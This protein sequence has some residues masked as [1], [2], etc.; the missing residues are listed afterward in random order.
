M[1][2]KSASARSG[3]VAVAP[4]YLIRQYFGANL[5]DRLSTRPFLTDIEK[6]W[7]IYQL[8]RAVEVSH[9]EGIMHGDIKPENFM[10]TSWNFIVL[11]DFANFKPVYMPDDD[12]KDFL[13]F[14]DSMGRR[15]CYVA[16]ERF[17]KQ[18]NSL[19]TGTTNPIDVDTSA[20]VNN[21]NSV[22]TPAMDV[23]SL[24]CTI[25]EIL[26]DGE[27]LIDLPGMLKYVSSNSSAKKITNL[28][29]EESP[30]LGTINRILDVTL[31]EVLHSVYYH[32]F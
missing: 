4:V 6:L 20:F 5:Y 31:R 16:P 19:G 13:Y 17:Y 23:F 11:T 22:L 29:D 27:P 12:P 25:A 7:I 18:S 28:C 32:Y 15:R 24:G 2:V 21:E 9:Q 26:L 8:M 1:W 30:A 10:I 3:K 14:F